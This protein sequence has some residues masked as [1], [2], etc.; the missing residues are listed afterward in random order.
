MAIADGAKFVIPAAVPSPMPDVLL[1]PYADG[2]LERV[3]EIYNHYVRTSIATF[4]VEPVASDR[5]ADW[6]RAHTTGEGHGIWVAEEGGRV[7]GYAASGP[8][9]P[10]PAYDRTVETAVYLDPA[11]TGRG[12]GRAL[13]GRL[14]ESLVQ[15]D[16]HR[17]IAVIAEPNPASEA[18]HRRFGFR[19][20]GRLSEVGWKFGK[21]WD[22][23]LFERGLP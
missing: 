3:A 5:Y 17:A 16:L 1:R 8:F 2:D 4:D 15:A 19:D 9:R 13:Y 14:F 7:L 6:V 11:S 12:L 22:V 23:A 20:V 21:H 18:L 10:R